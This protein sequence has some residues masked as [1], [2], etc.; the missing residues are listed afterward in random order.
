VAWIA[1][2]LL[3]ITVLTFA[4]CWWGSNV[5]FYP[6]LKIP[7]TVFPEQFD[8]KHEKKSFKT[9]DGVTLKGWLIPAEIKT[10][11]TILFCHGWGDNKGDMLDRHRLLQKKFNLFFFDNRAHG[12]SGGKHSSIGYLESIDFD[13]A[14]TYLQEHHA[15]LSKRIGLCGLSMGATVCVYGTANYPQVRGAV[16]ESPFQSFNEVVEQFTAN[17][18]SLPYYPFVWLTLI[19]IR[20]RLGTD[21]ES[22][23]PTYH[24]K[25]IDKPLFFIAGEEDRLMPLKRVQSLYDDAKQPKSMWVIPEATHGRCQ[26]IAGVEYSTRIR[27]FFEANL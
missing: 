11:R 4:A 8:L 20:F 9:Q 2:G 15:S 22:Y 21:P 6:P 26:E 1:F 7:L 17:S 14:I 25:N 19:I 16:L 10:D 27:D 18:Y 13:A 24:I 5:V 23:S 12:D 3:G